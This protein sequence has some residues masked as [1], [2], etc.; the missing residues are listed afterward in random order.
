M[1]NQLTGLFG[2]K[3]SIKEKEMRDLE[4]REIK[5]IQQQS[6][7]ET[8]WINQKLEGIV[9]EKLQMTLNDAFR[10]AFEVVFDKGNAMIEKTYKKKDHEN[11]Y[12]VNAYVLKLK[13][14]RK[15]IQSFSKQAKASSAKNLVISSVEGIGLGALG[16]GLPDI[17]LFTGVLLKSI[18]EIALSYGF[19]YEEEKEQIFILK[20]IEVALLTGE[21]LSKQNKQIDE[22]I[23]REGDIEVIDISKKEQ[24][25]KTAE[26]LSDALLYMKFIQGIPIVGVVG[27]AADTIY[28]KKIT[29]YAQLKY[30]RRFL[31]TSN[32]AKYFNK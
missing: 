20:L 19:S 8:S 29:Y 32:I 13:Q 23:L 14:N 4:K 17:P 7:K 26:S 31:Q 28:L 22:W 5:F 24:I 30:K 15:A 6:S 3:L 27:G 25:K 1:K 12:K 10:K 18:Y 21:E 11:N 16:I 2:P 9:P